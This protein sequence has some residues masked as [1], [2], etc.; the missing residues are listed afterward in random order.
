MCNE[1]VND[2]SDGSLKLND[3]SENANENVG[4]LQLVM[5]TRTPWLRRRSG[6]AGRQGTRRY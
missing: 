2:G 6:K 1:I 3:G 5:A 4:S